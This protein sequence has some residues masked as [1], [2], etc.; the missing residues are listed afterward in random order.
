MF[1]FGTRKWHDWVFENSIEIETTNNR[2]LGPVK[3]PRKIV[4]IYKRTRIRDGKPQYKKIII[5]L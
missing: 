1:G 2:I 3:G 5:W 4:Q